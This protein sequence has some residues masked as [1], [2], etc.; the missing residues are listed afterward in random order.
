[1]QFIKEGKRIQIDFAEKFLSR[2]CYKPLYEIIFDLLVMPVAVAYY[3]AG[4]FVLTKTFVA[5]S[6]M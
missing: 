6:K 4:R 2:R 1:M 3:L 5:S